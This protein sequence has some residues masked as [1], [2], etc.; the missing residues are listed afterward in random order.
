MIEALLLW[1]ALLL[2]AIIEITGID[3]VYDYCDKNKVPYNRN[4]KLIVAVEPEEIP[5]LQVFFNC[6]VFQQQRFVWL[7]FF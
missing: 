5:R 3:L 7:F 1:S 4:G 6:L 2:L